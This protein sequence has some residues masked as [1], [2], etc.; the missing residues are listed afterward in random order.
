MLSSTKARR[1]AAGTMRSPTVLTAPPAAPTI[2]LDR[3]R[4]RAAVGPTVP[5]DRAL[6]GVATLA[7]R[8]PDV[9]VDVERTRE[10][11]RRLTDGYADVALLRAP[12]HDRSLSWA[13]TAREPRMALVAA[14]HPLAR[15]GHARVM[16]LRGAEILEPADDALGLGRPLSEVEELLALVAAGRAVA[17]VPRGLATAAPPVVTGVPLPTAMPSTIVVAHRRAPEPATA[18]YVDAVLEAAAGRP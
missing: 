11:E 16:D 13:V 8:M 15:A 2:A 3:T 17:V 12:V 4:L 10:A 18:A 6:A 9:A 1:D 7:R 5:L 14:D